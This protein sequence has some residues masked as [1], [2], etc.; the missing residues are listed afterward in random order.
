M[1]LEIA[2]ESSA[3]PVSAVPMATM[4]GGDSTRPSMLKNL[5]APRMFFGI[6]HLA[7]TTWLTE[8]LHW[9]CLSKVPKSDLWDV[10]ATQITSG[11]LTMINVRLR[12]VEDLGVEP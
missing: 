6:K 12:I 4:S 2:A 1:P 8:M 7:V 9:N 5:E 10:M 3:K 11:P